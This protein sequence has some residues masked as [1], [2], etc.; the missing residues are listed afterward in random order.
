[1]HIIRPVASI[2]ISAPALH[3]VAPALHAVALF[4]FGYSLTAPLAFAQDI[5]YVLPHGIAPNGGGT[6]MNQSTIIIDMM[7][8]NEGN[9]IAS[10]LQI[11]NPDNVTDADLFV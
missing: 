9:D 2:R 1:M 10:I 5:A 6:R 4:M 7:W 8:S 11:H 3:A